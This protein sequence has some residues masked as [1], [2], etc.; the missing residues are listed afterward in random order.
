MLVLPWVYQS[1]IKTTFGRHK[2]QYLILED[3][4]DAGLLGHPLALTR[5][6]HFLMDALRVRS[7][8]APRHT[9][10]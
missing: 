7:C 4:S 2:F 9:A 8:S 1:A 5:L 10:Q 6:L 3:S